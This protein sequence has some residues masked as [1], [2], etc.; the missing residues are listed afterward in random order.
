MRKIKEI[1]KEFGVPVLA[2]ALPLMASA[3]FQGPG[4]TAPASPV[5]SVSQLTGSGGLF[6]TIINWLFYLLIIAAIV[7]VLVSAFK[8]LTA[9]GDP[10]KVKAAG[11]T[12]LYAAIAVII[13]LVAK[14]IP[15][16]AAS[17]I[18]GGGVSAC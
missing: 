1:V 17:F 3:Q 2:L 14:G 12:L 11:A 6:C 13:A 18:G 15:F 8:Y 16:I 5:T 9:A 4:I 7:F 10:E